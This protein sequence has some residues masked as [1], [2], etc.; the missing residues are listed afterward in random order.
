MSDPAAP[1][2]DAPIR[3]YRRL[4]MVLV[5]AAMALL[6]GVVFYYSNYYRAALPPEQPIPF[7]HRVHAG[8]K[9]ISCLMCHNQV[10]D[11]DHAGIPPVQRCML[12]HEKIIIEHPKIKLVR[13]HYAQK[14]PILW[15]RVNNLPDFVYFTHR[16]HIRQG[17][18]CGECHGNVSGMDR[19]MLAN[20]FK[21][22]FCLDC[23]RK[24][25]APHDCFTCHR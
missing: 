8:Q 5:I 24:K 6:G 21:M 4:G 15:A 2:V 14:Q 16:L 12:C 9:Q 25:N 17:L 7:S 10:I 22:G 19:V 23:H 13:E 18:D 11:S 20:D 1:K 3:P